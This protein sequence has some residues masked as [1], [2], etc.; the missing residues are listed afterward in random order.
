MGMTSPA[1]ILNSL[2]APEN[3]RYLLVTVVTTLL[4]AF[5]ALSG[6]TDAPKVTTGDVASGPEAGQ[7]ALAP[8]ESLAPG[9]AGQTGT[10]GTATKGKAARKGSGAGAGET[11]GLPPITDTQIK[12]GIQYVED[13]GT[14]NQ[15]AGFAGIGQVDQK[16]GWEAM[17]KEVNRSAP[18]GRKVVP[19]YY[20]FTTAD[21]T[22]KG[23]P[24]INAEACAKW[25]KDDRV[26]I[27][28]TSGDDNLR[29]CLTKGKV[30][31]LGGG[32]GFS[33]EQTFKD[34]PWLVEHN[35][36][37]LDRMA[38]FE[39]DQLFERGFFAK[40]KP[41][42]STAPCVD[43]KPRIGLIRYD[44]P[45]YKAG[46]IRMKKALASHGLQLCSGCEFEVTY[47]SDSVPAQLDD[48]T[49]VNSAIN[50]CRLPHSAPGAPDGPCTHMLFLGSTAGVRITLF[51]V[52]RAEDQGY[53]ARLGFNSLDAPS[54]VRDFFAS[55]DQGEK[56][57]HQFENSILV[58]SGPADF[59]LL[60]AAFK[61]CMK[62]WTD[63]GETFGG[64][65]D[66]AGNK[67]GQ[68]DGFCD[69]AWYH[70]A[71]F[72]AAGRTVTLDSWLNGVANTGLVKSAGTFLMRTTANR[73]DGAGA[74]RVGDYDAGGACHC[75]KPVTGDIPV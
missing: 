61:D 63:A 11:V 28:W 68:I 40:C 18:F 54:A 20:S 57:N 42:P 67:D 10:A 39:V 55:A 4:L 37:A 32:S 46:A 56:Y 30:A 62:L 44:Q 38:E 9:A 35:S 14:A 59:D 13:P 6:G 27:A 75:W 15:A 12:V 65:D 16:R 64:S 29:A 24:A 51:Y 71:A 47:S 26:F 73:H 19:V 72:N 8:G 58:S 69:T 7:E 66:S 49:E 50:N 74:V 41:D 22:S 33:Y 43:G 5:L 52:Q 60:P 2:R 53:R 3:R 25:T 31:M 23:G 34:Y 21:L 1:Q 17:I 70:I 48:A 45:S 36:S